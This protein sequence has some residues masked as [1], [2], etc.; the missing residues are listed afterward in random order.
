MTAAPSALAPS[1][2]ASEPAPGERRIAGRLELH[3]DGRVVR[4]PVHVPA[5]GS[6]P[7]PYGTPPPLPVTAIG[8]PPAETAGQRFPPPGR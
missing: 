5:P 7:A 3:P 1:A 2:L 8:T 4:V 6:R